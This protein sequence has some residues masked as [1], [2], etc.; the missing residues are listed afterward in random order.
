MF[1]YISN[2]RRKILYIITIPI[3]LSLAGCPEDPVVYVAPTGKVY[4]T[5]DCSSLRDRKIPVPLS[6]AL[7]SGYTPHR[8]CSPP[9]ETNVPPPEYEV[10]PLVLPY[11]EDP[12]RIIRYKGFVLLYN[13]EYEQA[14]WVAYLLTKE[15]EAGALDRPKNFRPDVNIETGSASQDDYDVKGYI[16]EPGAEPKKYDRGHLAPDADMDWDFLAVSQ[17]YLFS[18]MSPMVPKFNSGIWAK[19]EDWVREQVKAS[20]EVYVVTGPVLT[21]GPY[22]EIG[23]NMMDVP[24]RYF[25]VILDY[26]E[27]EIKTI[28]FIIPN[29]PSDEPL[30]NYAMSV[31]QVET[32]TGLEFFHSLENAQEEELESQVYIGNWED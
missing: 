26:K 20:E 15:E 12:E 21:N 4:H 29:E 11:C 27:P 25:K 19:L 8:A 23:P 3:F 2:F 31:N 7:F 30:A 22:Q 6:E 14:S 5:E 13:E 10:E 16:P 24:K 28:G 18:N 17:T 1:T 32:E 9:T